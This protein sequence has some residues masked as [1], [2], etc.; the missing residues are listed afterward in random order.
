MG[1]LTCMELAPAKYKWFSWDGVEQDEREDT[2]F[3]KDAEEKGV[4]DRR[5]GQQYKSD[6]GEIDPGEK[7]SH[8][9][10]EGVKSL[11]KADGGARRLA[12]SARIARHSHFGPTLTVGPLFAE[13]F[14]ENPKR[15]RRKPPS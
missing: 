2:A 15:R 6:R 12:K 9:H 14:E 4:N 1:T 7:Y 13:L 10:D 11:R 3:L 8:G 5:E